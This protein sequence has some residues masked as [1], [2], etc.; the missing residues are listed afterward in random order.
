MLG[1]F[2]ICRGKEDFFVLF[3]F[4]QGFGIL[5]LVQV[6]SHE[7]MDS[8]IWPE[9]MEKIF[10]RRVLSPSVGHVCIM[11][12]LYKLY[13]LSSSCSVARQNHGLLSFSL[14]QTGFFFSAQ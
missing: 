1:E 7:W 2:H 11:Y 3:C 12:L 8:M 4:I 13:L 10:I 5:E 6:A 14:R 9:L